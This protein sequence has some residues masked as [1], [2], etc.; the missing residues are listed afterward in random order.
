MRE[1]GLNGYR[2]SV[3]WPRI[4]PT[5]RG[6]I[7][8]AGLDFYDR[9]VDEVLAA[10]MRPFA[11]LYHWDL[12][13]ALE[14][15]GRLAEPG[16]RA[17][18]RR[19]R[20][21]RGQATGRPRQGLDHA[22]RALV[23]LLPQ[24]PARRSRPGALRLERGDPGEPHAQPRARP[25]DPGDPRGRRWARRHHPEPLPGHPASDSEEDR[26]AA[27]RYD[28]FD[29]RWFL[30]PV[31][32][33]SYPA[34]MLEPFGPY[35]PT[36]ERRD[37]ATACQPLDFLGINFYSRAIVADRPDRA[38]RSQN[39]SCRAAGRRRADRHGLGG[40]SGRPLRS[41][42]GGC[43]GTMA[44]ST[45]TSRRTARRIPIPSLGTVRCTT[46]TGGATWHATS[47]RPPTRFAPVCL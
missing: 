8:S 46:R 6:E 44:R 7:N 16:H 10:G 41:C 23:H 38:E 15:R 21:D 36:I 1:L 18:V 9:L 11:T 40:L 20:R 19:V 26:A 5:G 37:L 28:G 42:S 33:G 29:N 3:A 17:R 30:D 34:D 35:A 22:E 43:N 14:D 39:P 2:F 47:R 45:S 13:Q 25:G 24:L 27:V 4:Y 12:P 32:K 31:L